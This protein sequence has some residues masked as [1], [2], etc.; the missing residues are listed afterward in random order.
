M[1]A[2]DTDASSVFCSLTSF[3]S[4]GL[5]SGAGAA[6]TDEPKRVRTSSRCGRIAFT[7]LAK[8]SDSCTSSHRL[9]PN[10]MPASV[11]LNSFWMVADPQFT[12]ALSFSASCVR[13]VM[14]GE[15]AA[16]VPCETRAAAAAAAVRSASVEGAAAASLSPALMVDRGKSGSSGEPTDEYRSA[17]NAA[18]WSVPMAALASIASFVMGLRSRLMPAPRFPR[19]AHRPMD[20]GRSVSWLSDSC[21]TTSRDMRPIDWGSVVSLLLPR[22]SSSSR[23]M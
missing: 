23:V 4:V 10:F 8:P 11:G 12:S 14:T 20:R 3:S 5:R 7:E 22:L 6:A 16:M 17:R 1:R 9:M 18:R 15:G 13:G 21:S 2:S 19:P